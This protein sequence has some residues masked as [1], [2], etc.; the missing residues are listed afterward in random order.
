M[1]YFSLLKV[2]YGHEVECREF[3]LPV[4]SLQPFIVLR[5]WNY[6][7]VPNDNTHNL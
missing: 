3:G 7:P 5:S 2:S 6:H 1:S 4:F